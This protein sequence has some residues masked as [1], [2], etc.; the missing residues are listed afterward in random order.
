MVK[1]TL[2]TTASLLMLATTAFGAC[3]SYT[4]CADN[5]VHWYD[6]TNGEVCDPL[7]C[8]GGRAPVK[9]DVPC[10]A[11]YRGT[12]PCIITTS[13]LSCWSPSTAP[14]PSAIASA[15]ADETTSS[16]AT[17]TADTSVSS[18]T[19][20]SSTG[21]AAETSSHTKSGTT[22]APSTTEPPTQLS[23]S[24]T[25][26]TGSTSTSTPPVSTNIA[27]GRKNPNGAKELSLNG[28]NIFRITDQSLAF[29]VP[30]CISVTMARVSVVFTLF[31]LLAATLVTAFNQTLELENGDCDNNCYFSS[32]PG[33]SCTDDVACMCNKHK[34]REAY[35]CCMKDCNPNVM[36]ESITRQHR[37]CIARNLDFTFDAE[38]RCGVKLTTSAVLNNVGFYYFGGIFDS[39]P[40]GFFGRKSN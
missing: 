22:A 32:F 17:P 35:F 16:T 29:V 10:C 2:S 5:I 8:G 27:V 3:N 39:F 6:P 1:T 26:E 28:L 4:T 37:E 12:E 40:G 25:S 11:A 18:S 21:A 9:Y 34:Y 19:G 38:A 31:A 20:A 24:A 30:N 14:T 36:P 7:N 23:N 33:G 15:S 13:T